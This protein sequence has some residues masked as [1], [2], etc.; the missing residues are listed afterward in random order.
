MEMNFCRRCGSALNKSDTHVYT[1]QNGHVIFANASPAVAIWL[2][3]E[4]NEVR[5]INPGKG[6]LD[7]PGG[8]IDGATEVFEEANERELM[9]EIGIT[10][11]QHG[12]L[13]YLSSGI[14][15]YEYK[16]EKI[17]VL[18]VFFWARID[19]SV[20]FTP[21]DDV[22][23]VSYMDIDTLDPALMY[24]NAAREALIALRKLL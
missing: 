10:K 14:D 19:S 3:N 1:C 12:P 5:A 22:E 9:E 24:F 21:Q 17:P 23:S 15:H 13:Q 2:I 6:L 20:A 4:K 16:G 8:F 11:D 7:T 18:S